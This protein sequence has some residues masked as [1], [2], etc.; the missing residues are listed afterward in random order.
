MYKRLSWED[1]SS[2][3]L[4]K[5]DIEILKHDTNLDITKKATDKF[6]SDAVKIRDIYIASRY[7]S[8]HVDK[9]DVAAIKV[10]YKNL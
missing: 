5:E 7:V 1:V 4:N 10:L 9:E 3:K 8:G 2:D 6:G